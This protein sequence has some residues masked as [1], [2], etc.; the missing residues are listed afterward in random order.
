MAVSASRTLSNNNEPIKV[1]TG[2]VVRV[3]DGDTITILDATNTQNKI[4]LYGIDAPEKAQDFGNKSR[5]K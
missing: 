5:E 1:I 3:A 2:K 4:R